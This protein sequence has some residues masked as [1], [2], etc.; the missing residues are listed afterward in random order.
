MSREPKRLGTVGTIITVLV[1]LSLIAAIGFVVWQILSEGGFLYGILPVVFGCAVGVITFFVIN[2][3][4]LKMGVKPAPS[5]Y[6][7]PQNS[8]K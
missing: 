6:E 7:E 1:I 5:A 4:E 8:L 2:A 3:I